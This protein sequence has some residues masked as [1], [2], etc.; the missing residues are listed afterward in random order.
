[1][2]KIRKKRKPMSE[3]QRK[4]AGERLAKARAKRQA[5]NPPQYKY[6]H[7]SVLALKEDDPFYFR[8]VQQWIKTQ[9]EELS[10]ARRDL[11]SKIK[12]A[13]ARVASIQAYIRNLE[14]FLRDG[15]YVDSFYGEYQQNKIRHKC[16]HMA[17]DAN[18]N[19]KRTHG[20]FYPDLG[21]TWDDLT[22]GDT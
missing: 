14:K 20:V 19:A 21:I 6:I 18:G 17:Y 10:I 16:I 22:M 3:E 1:M 2:V 7:E 15:D 5:A 8:K 9:K 11:R 13:E 4:A 12:G